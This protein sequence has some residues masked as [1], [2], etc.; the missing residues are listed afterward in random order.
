MGSV[1]GAQFAAQAVWLLVNLHCVPILVSINVFNPTWGHFF[2]DFSHG[3]API[4]ELCV[5]DLAQVLTVG[6]W[7]FRTVQKP[8]P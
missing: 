1:A 7:Q 5:K 2:I 6:L 3:E 8:N 4:D